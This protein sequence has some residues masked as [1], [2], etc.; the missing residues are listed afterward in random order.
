MNKFEL[1][2]NGDTNEVKSDEEIYK[3]K[4][5]KCHFNNLSEQHLRS[6]KSIVDNIDPYL[7]HGVEVKSF[8]FSAHNPGMHSYLL[9]KFKTAGDYDSICINSN[10][11]DKNQIPYYLLHELGHAFQEQIKEIAAKEGLKIYPDEGEDADYFKGCSYR[12]FQADLFVGYIMDKEY[13]QQN[14]KTE[15]EKNTFQVYEKLFVNNNFE[16]IKNSIHENEVNYKAEILKKY[17][18]G[19]IP[20]PVWLDQDYMNIPIHMRAFDEEINIQYRKYF[21]DL[22]RKYKQG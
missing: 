11:E 14:I 22:E 15:L 1:N 21:D 18:S 7:D 2:L 8:D 12:E 6:V 13:V 16:K 5:L 20:R 3:H 9:P 17:E 10:F 19:E 4:Y